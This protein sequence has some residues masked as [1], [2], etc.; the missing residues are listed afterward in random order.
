MTGFRFI[1]LDDDEGFEVIEEAEAVGELEEDEDEEAD[2]ID[3]EVIWE[4]EED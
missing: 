3:D 2:Q 1:F 4:T